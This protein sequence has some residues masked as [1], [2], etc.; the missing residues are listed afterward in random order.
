MNKDFITVENLSYFYG[1]CNNRSLQD[2]NIRIKKEDFILLCGESGSGKSTLIKCLCGSIPNFYGGKIRG[3]IY[4]EGK[5][6]KN[7]LPKDLKGKITVVFQHPEKQ[8]IMNKVHREIAFGIENIGLDERIIK[9]RVMESLQFCNILHLAYKDVDSLS[10]GEKQKVSIASALAYRPECIILDEPTSQL[11][12]LSKE[13]IVNII[14]KINKEFGITIIVVEQRIEKWFECANKIAFMKKGKLDFNGTSEE[15]IK[16]YEKVKYFLP[17]H[18]NIL[19]SLGIYNIYSF[20]ETRQYLQENFLKYYEKSEVTKCENNSEIIK[21]ENNKEVIIDIDDLKY[22]YKN[23]SDDFRIKDINLKVHKQDVLS[24]IGANGAGKSTFLKFLAGILKYKG[25]IKIFNK[26][27]R[28]YKRKELS[29]IV[30][31]VSQNPQD[32]ISKDT[33]YEELKFTLDNFN[34]KSYDIIDKILKKLHIYNIKDKNPRDISGGE[35]QRVAIASMLVL[36]PK[37]LLLDEPTRGLHVE[38]KNQLLNL[39]R[40]INQEGTTIILVTHDM[41]F[42]ANISNKVM[43][44]FNGEVTALDSKDKVLKEGIFYTTSINKLFR[45]IDENIFTLE[46]LKASYR[47]F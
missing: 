15:F 42:V 19:K 12:P 39:L 45:N 9:R 30:A 34:I 29:S 32:Y 1:G 38:A 35:K 24:I 40:E 41:N 28:K 33:V 20:K 18:I 11:D 22:S 31:Y 46:D 25:S 23:T 26:E 27:L 8:I 44:M 2:I 4:I 13:E 6:L 37:I 3:N 7:I 36:N 43:V 21:C 10:G 47:K 5:N 16:H 14:K 17:Q